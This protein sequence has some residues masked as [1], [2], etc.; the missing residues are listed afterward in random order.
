MQ[1]EPYHSQRTP[2]EWSGARLLLE[3]WLVKQCG[4]ESFVNF[5]SGALFGLVSI[6]ALIFTSGVTAA[7]V[8]FVLGY[9]S[10]LLAFVGIHISLLR[11]FLFGLLFTTFLVLSVVH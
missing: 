3:K 4:M 5:L 11:P 6:F 9:A 2:A 1:A 8:L 10:L 7:L